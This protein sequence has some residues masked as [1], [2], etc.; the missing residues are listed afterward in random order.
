M[1]AELQSQ[2]IAR[3][4][5]PIWF[6]AMTPSHTAL[7]AAFDTSTRRWRP[8]ASA[9]WTCV[10]ALAIPLWATWPTLALRTRELPIFECLGVAYLVAWLALSALER[11]RSAVDDGAARTSVGVP[12]GYAPAGDAAG[13]RA[14]IPATIFALGLSGSA[15]LFVIATHY[16][17]A[18][19]ANLI[20]YLWPGMIAA[21]GAALRL[22]RLR[23]RQ[24]VGIALGFVGAAIVLRN[25]S[26]SFSY[27]GMGLSLL[28]GALWA[29]YC[30]Y[31]LKWPEA[32]RSI[33]AQ[34]C[35]MSGVL[36]ALLH[37]LVEPTVVPSMGTAAAAMIIGLIPTALGNF[38]WD[39]GFRRGDSK[40]L[41]VMAYA[42]PLCSAL[43][44]SLF[45]IESLTWNLLIGAVVIAA[46]GML[47][48]A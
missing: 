40:L 37:F 25:G 32:P 6:S 1:S 14:W 27:Q 24:I 26:L 43:L 34:G 13:W 28:G 15:A 18:A 9:L 44:L 11:A 47:S 10:G 39:Q 31:R 30:V 16:I 3:H 42:T 8:P 22:F 36:C 20:T 19:E 46:A 4:G 21:F 48:R 17:A 23:P 7:F 2:A 38:V 45:G 12:A 35:A 29:A 33:L 41:A 5:F